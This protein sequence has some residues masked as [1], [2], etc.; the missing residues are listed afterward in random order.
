M[1]AF[2]RSLYD[3]GTGAGSERPRE[4]MNMITAWIDA[5]NVYGSDGARASALR[6]LDGSGRLEMGAGEL[7]PY[8]VS[9]LSNAG[10]PGPD[11]FLAGD[12]RANEQVALSAMHTLFVR[13][14]NRI[15]AGLRRLFRDWT[16]DRI[17]E[18]ARAL[19]GAEM[20]AITY[21]EFLPALLGPHALAPYAGYDPGV[22]ASIAN[23]FSSACYRFGHSMLGTRLLR[24][25]SWNREIPEGH[26]AL[27]DA[28]FAPWRITEEGGISPLLRGLA[29]QHAERVDPYIVDDVRNFL[30]GPPGSGGLDLAA[31]NI[32]RGRDHGLPSYVESRA[33][34]GLVV[35]GD[36]ADVTSDPG[37]QGRLEAT[38]GSVEAVDV[39]VGGL[40][41][42]HLPGAM[43]GEL[44]HTVLRLQFESLRDGD[45]YFYSTWL[46]P[47]LRRGLGGVRLA[48]VIR[49]NT[50]IR[51][52]IPDDVFH[53]R[54][55]RREPR[56]RRGGRRGRNRLRAGPEDAL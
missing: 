28:F 48:H 8:N 27:R 5:S 12:V 46:G 1:I 36:F 43:L 4:Q 25:D 50:R 10:G 44:L 40:A 39:W 38:Y 20:Q 9:G 23:L 56:D 45:R 52:E 30:F 2:D 17:Y 15:A 41:E 49:R 42:D 55:L 14:H 51:G 11:L 26:L 3:P 13:E 37:L 35:P 47:R 34:L 21:E 54:P 22:D 32:Q 31:L 33:K 19:V 6:A 7:L 53:V 24:L 29:A 18:A 16:G